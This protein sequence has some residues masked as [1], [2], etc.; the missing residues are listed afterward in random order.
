MAAV[1][2]LLDTTVLLNYFR[3]NACA[4][5]IEADYALRAS[6]FAPTISVVSVGEMLSFALNPDWDDKKRAKLDS[7]LEQCIVIDL[8]QRDVLDGYACL[9]DVNTKSGLSIGQND[10]WIAA[11]ANAAGLAVLTSDK[12]FERIPANLVRVIKVHPKTG[13]TEGP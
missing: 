10:L 5:Q 11:C 3:W 9:H 6:G 1:E 4:Q 7:F 12:D 13:V 8:R 2:T